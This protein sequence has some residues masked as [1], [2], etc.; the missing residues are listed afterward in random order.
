[1]STKT[2][3]DNITELMLALPTRELI[4]S[5]TDEQ[6]ERYR[7]VGNL[8]DNIVFLEVERR[9]KAKEQQP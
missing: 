8:L 2:V 5:A 4:S 6:L 3:S 1:M 9:Q 7:R